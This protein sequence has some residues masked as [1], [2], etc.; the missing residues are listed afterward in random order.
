MEFNKSPDNRIIAKIILGG[1]KKYLSEFLIITRRSRLRFEQ[2]KWH[3]I[4]K[5]T[6]DRLNLY[7]DILCEISERINGYFNYQENK[8][9]TWTSVKAQYADLIKSYCNRNIAETFFNSLTRKIFGFVGINRDLEFFHLHAIEQREPCGPLIY[10]TYQQEESTRNLLQ[11]IINDHRFDTE[12]ENLPRDLEYA[13]NELNLFL[14]LITRNEKSYSVDVLNSAFYRNKVA[15]I[16]G[17]VVVDSQIYPLII[18]LYNDIDGVYI[19]SVL[20]DE[21]DVNNIFGFAYSYFNVD[22]NLP[23]QLIHFLTSILPDKPISELY[24]SIGF[25]RHGKTEFYRD[26]HRFVHISKE[27]FEYAPGKEGA[28]MLVYTL[29]HYNY[30]FKLIKDKPCFVRSSGTTDKTITKEQVKMRYD[31]VC[32]RD[33]V[34]RLVDTQEFENL[35][36][37]KKRFSDELLHDFQ[38]IANEAVTIK[39]EYVVINHLFLQRKVIPLPI[40]F[41][42]ESNI[43]LVRQVIIDFGYFIKDLAATGLFP[44]DLFNTWN[45]GVSEGNRVVLYD[46]DDVIPLE[47]SKFKLK[48][49]PKND[50][51]EHSLEEDWIM[52][53]QNDF[54]LDE[55]D[56]YI[57]IPEPLKGIFNSVHSDLFALNYWENIKSKVLKGEVIDIIPYDR[58][59]RFKRFSREV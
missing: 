50:Y 12:Y 37:R 10:K 35:R 11:K 34:G 30:V 32:K 16:I 2:K 9:A 33:R 23:N 29:P 4:K 58:T 36:F 26:L 53:D 55:V 40:Y 42:T 49:V 14:W 13:A 57:G 52:A 19:D 44:A 18:P 1:F 15:Y 24:N 46:Y 21:A 54:F 28:V 38:K 59:K 17:R 39:N 31:F 5:D 3:E 56:R 6:V 22:I 45:Y 51:E 41:Y 20:L 48:P 27:K 7:E 25:Y 47:G 43:N 8:T